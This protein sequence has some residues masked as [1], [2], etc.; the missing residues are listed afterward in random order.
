ML[1]KACLP[2]DVLTMGDDSIN[3]LWREAKLKA[4]GIN[5]ATRLVDADKKQHRS[6][7]LRVIY[8]FLL[9]HV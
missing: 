1:E 6:D 7:L 5:K 8:S 3:A 4:V 2:A 9:V